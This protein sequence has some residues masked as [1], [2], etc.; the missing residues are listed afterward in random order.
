MRTGISTVTWLDAVRFNEPWFIPNYRIKLPEVNFNNLVQHKI[1]YCAVILISETEITN[2]ISCY[3]SPEVIRSITWV[4]LTHLF[5]LIIVV[6][7]TFKL[8]YF[9][10]RQLSHSTTQVLTSLHTKLNLSQRALILASAENTHW[11]HFKTN[12]VRWCYL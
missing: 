6:L 10:F 11:H 4:I 12:I 8:F 2:Q 3:I 5:Y 1:Q 7:K 9:I